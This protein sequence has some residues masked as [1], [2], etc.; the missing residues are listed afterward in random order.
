MSSGAL[1]V[2]T[3]VPGSEASPALAAVLPVAAAL[4]DGE[5]LGDVL[6]LLAPLAAAGEPEVDEAAAAGGG[7]AAAGVRGLCVGLCSGLVSGL[8]SDL[9]ASARPGMRG[10]VV[11]ASAL[12]SRH[13]DMACSIFSSASRSDAGFWRLRLGDRLLLTGGVPLTSSVAVVVL[14]PLPRCSDTPSSSSSSRD[15]LLR[16]GDLR[17]LGVKLLLRPERLMATTTAA[18]AAVV[19]RYRALY[20]CVCLSGWMRESHVCRRSRDTNSAARTR[21]RTRSQARTASL[22]RWMPPWLGAAG[23]AAG[24]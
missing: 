5:P 22:W 24:E 12:V 2:T 1:M 15:D 16:A 20:V 17:S 18:A 7:V 8:V 13:C 6:A 23:G 14:A 11:V 10:D 9:R 21:T 4:A 3:G 19:L